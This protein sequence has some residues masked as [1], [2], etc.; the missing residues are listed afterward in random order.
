MIHQRHMH[1][2][3]CMPQM[4]GSSARVGGL[5]L[6]CQVFWVRGAIAARASPVCCLCHCSHRVPLPLGGPSVQAKSLRFWVCSEKPSR[7]WNDC[8]R[9]WC[10]GVVDKGNCTQE[11]SSRAMSSEVPA[12]LLLAAASSC[13]HEDF[14]L[15]LG[16][17]HQ[18]CFKQLWRK[19]QG[20]CRRLVL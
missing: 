3:A 10:W 13:W 9:G 8:V 16:D 19:S 7:T 12:G 14:K 2:G 15:C 11:L 18:F 17:G 20:A 4:H 6:M 5:L 1:I